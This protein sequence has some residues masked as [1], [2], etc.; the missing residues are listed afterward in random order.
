MPHRHGS[1]RAG[2]L[3]RPAV[4][5]LCVEPPN[6]HLYLYHCAYS[7]VQ[8][9]EHQITFRRFS[10][11]NIA[12]KLIFGPSEEHFLEKENHHRIS[13]CLLHSVGTCP[14]LVVFGATVPSSFFLRRLLAL[15]AKPGLIISASFHEGMYSVMFAPTSQMSC[16]LL[17]NY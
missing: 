4:P 14:I 3:S 12:S 9:C 13:C 1:C 17:Q 16:T 11:L 10:S 15:C 5:A 8:R 7:Y 6:R 2:A